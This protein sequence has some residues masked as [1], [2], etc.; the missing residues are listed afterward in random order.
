MWYCAAISAIVSSRASTSVRVARHS[1]SV[2]IFARPPLRPRVR[3]GARQ[4]Q[5]RKSD[6]VRRIKYG[7]VELSP[8]ISIE[9]FDKVL[10]GSR[11]QKT[12]TALENQNYFSH[13][14]LNT[15]IVGAC[16]GA[17]S[18]DCKQEKNSQTAGLEHVAAYNKGPTC[19]LTGVTNEIGS[20]CRS[21]PAVR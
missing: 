21:Q 18:R 4:A 20:L 7:S 19:K 15:E 6:I 14:E 10:V 1:R 8:G 5:V 11:T 9:L 12:S 2:S 17:H 3:A 16:L 13:L